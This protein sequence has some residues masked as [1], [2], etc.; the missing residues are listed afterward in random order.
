MSIR[1]QPFQHLKPQDSKEFA[2]IQLGEIEKEKHFKHLNTQNHYEKRRTNT[3]SNSSS[4][5]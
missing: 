4:K 2:Y 3:G 1:I 5:P